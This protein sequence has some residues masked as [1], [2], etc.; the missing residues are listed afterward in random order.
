MPS[1]GQR[2]QEERAKR[3]L[4]IEEI[5]DQTRINPAYIQAIESDDLSSLPGGFFYRSFV[6]QYARILGLPE[7]EYAGYL[8]K[9]LED[10][11]RTIEKLETA[12][13]ARHIAV[14]P[15]PTGM[16]NKAEETRRWVIRLSVLVAVIVLCSGVYYVYQWWRTTQEIAA[17][18]QA[19]VTQAA[20]EPVKPPPPVVQTPPQESGTMPATQEPT[21]GA[22]SAVT[23]PPPPVSSSPVFVVVNAREQVWAGVTVDG[24]TVFQAALNPGESKTFEANERIRVRLG[25]AG[26][27]DITYNGKAIPAVGPTGQVRTVEFNPQEYRLVFPPKPAAPASDAPATQTPPQQ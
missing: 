20:P 10:E 12:L 17:Q 24:K 21:P 7:S 3:G 6:R 26:G 15:M 8:T 27:A 22:A 9:S 11:V 2:L 14:P 4:S 13:P 19:A 16:V 5:A 25:N 23:Q 18:Q 1:L